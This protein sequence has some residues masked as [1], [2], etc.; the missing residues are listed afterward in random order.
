MKRSKAKEP[1]LEGQSFT[2]KQ[3][4]RKVVL[5]TDGSIRVYTPDIFAYVSLSLEDLRFVLESL[6]AFHRDFGGEK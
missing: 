4:E 1:K 3:G 6:N 5:S 2:Y